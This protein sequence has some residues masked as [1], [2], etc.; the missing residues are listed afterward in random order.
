MFGWSEAVDGFR[1]WETE[2]LES[3]RAA[4]VAEQRRLHVEELAI[5]RVLDERGRI[6][7]SLA[8]VDGIDLRDLREKVDRAR[9]FDVLPEIASAARMARNRSRGSTV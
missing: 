2:A 6:D 9:A 8:A 7:D 4:V 1:C 5:T 3:R